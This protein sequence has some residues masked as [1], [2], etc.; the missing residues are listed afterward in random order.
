MDPEKKG[1]EGLV[2]LFHLA[3]KLKLEKRRGWLDR[4]VER[5]ESVS[6]HSFRLALMAMLFAERQGLDSCKAAKMALIHDL[7]EAI[8]GDVATRISEELQK[9]PDKEKEEREENAMQEILGMLQGNTR[10]EIQS[11]WKE[12]SERKTKEARLVYELDRLE[13]I[14]QAT[15]YEK[16]KNFEVSLQ[17]FYDYMNGRLKNNELKQVFEMLMKERG[18]K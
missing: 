3:E 7:P 10:E 14:F 5:P 16:R 12:F 8:C 4:G 11:L 18:K 17:E 6:D 2:S 1:L 9:I 15:E 13:A